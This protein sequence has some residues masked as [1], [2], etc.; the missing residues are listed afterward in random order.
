[1]QKLYGRR[2]PLQQ[3]ITS[4]N[5]TGDYLTRSGAPGGYTAKYAEGWVWQSSM[6]G[7]VPLDIYWH[8][9]RGD[10]WAV[11]T[12][13]SRT[14]AENAGYVFRSR[15]G[16]IYAAPQPGT[17]ALRR[18]RSPNRLENITTAS[19]AAE[20]E[21]L[22]AGYTFIGDEGYIFRASDVPFD[23]LTYYWSTARND[24]LLTR[25]GSQLAQDAENEGYFNR[26]LDGIT[27][28]H[29]VEQTTALR[30]FWN[31]GRSDHFAAATTQGINAAFTDGYRELPR[32][33]YV[34][35]TSQNDTQGLRLYWNP[36][37]VD[38]FT[39]AENL[40]DAILGYQFVRNEGFVPPALW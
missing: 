8:F 19:A 38:N 12:S 18:Y 27:L 10:H 11:A 9:G 3:I 5:V 21:V 2:G 33:G 39:T 26:G 29:N 32:E 16:Y 22:A 6:P 31:T 30:Q 20:Q 4:R 35:T 14:A 34:F 23:T 25:T 1:M 24:S 36:L 28:K 15:A 40:S 13:G 37:T 7:T 17:N